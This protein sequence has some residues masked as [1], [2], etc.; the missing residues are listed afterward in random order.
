[1]MRKEEREVWKAL[2][3]WAAVRI[4]RTGAAGLS[5]AIDALLKADAAMPPGHIRWDAPPKEAPLAR[6]GVTLIADERVR[7]AEQEGFTPAHDDQH[8]SGSLALAAA[9]YAW[10]D[11]PALLV[12]QWPYGQSWWKPSPDDRVKEL[13]KAGALIAAEIDRLLRTGADHAG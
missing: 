6:C 7:Q 10:P 5:H 1:M 12:S 3:E 8:A 2:R 4:D 13:V 11:R 9:I